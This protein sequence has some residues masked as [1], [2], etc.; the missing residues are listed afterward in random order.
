MGQK[1]NWGVGTIVLGVVSLAML[2]V[3]GA[4]QDPFGPAMQNRPVNLVATGGSLLLVTSG[5]VT[6]VQAVRAN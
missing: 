5:V 3:T 6:V 4:F 1:F 2:G